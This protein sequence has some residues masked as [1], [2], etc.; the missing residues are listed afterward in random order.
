MQLPQW[1]AWLVRYG[2]NF[3]V[4]SSAI[5]LFWMAFFD[6]NDF[7]T[8]LRNWSYLRAAYAE[9][10]YYE[11]KIKEVQSERAAVLD[12]PKLLEKFAREK[13]LMKRPQEDLYLV[14]ED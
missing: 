13:Y 1:P 8:Q 7:F 5:F 2:R 6:G 10:V 9:K 14:V 11:D 12:D 3:Y 4:L